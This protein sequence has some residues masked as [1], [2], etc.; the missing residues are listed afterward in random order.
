MPLEQP[1]VDPRA[2]RG[3]ARLPGNLSAARAIGI[4][5]TYSP[6]TKSGWYNSSYETCTFQLAVEAEAAAGG[7][8]LHR[9]RVP[10]YAHSAR[11]PHP[12][13]L[14]RFDPVTGRAKMDVSHE[15]GERLL[16][17]ID[18]GVI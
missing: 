14:P 13:H 4:S 15:F 12:F 17:F 8:L 16:P 5:D 10:G 3:E 1:R 18:R 7:I 9:Q 6:R 2:R 11:T